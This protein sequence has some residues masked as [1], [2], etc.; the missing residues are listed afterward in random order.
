MASLI[1]FM[2][3]T[4][5]GKSTQADLLET[6]MGWKHISSGRLL[7]QSSGG[8]ELLAS[9][10]L[11]PSNVVEGLVGEALAKVKS[12]D[13][14]VLD[15]FPRTA[16]DSRWLDDYVKRTGI[17]L[18]AVVLLQVEKTTSI[19]RL[20][21]RQ[22][23]DDGERALAEKWLEYEQETMPVLNHYRDQGL[24]CTID[25]NGNQEEVQDRIIKVLNI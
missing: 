25:A 21:E 2:G 18:Q 7:R 4:G 12:G 19:N 1:L 3:A 16:D 15:G 10:R 22:R 14:V 9:G 17:R 23:S 5:S 6:V 24:L 13:T 20:H 11:A 8:E